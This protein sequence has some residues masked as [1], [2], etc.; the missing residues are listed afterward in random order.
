MSIPTP[1]LL[2][3]A[4]TFA[5]A[6]HG[7][8][9]DK[10]KVPYRHHLAAVA[11]G[12][13]LLGGTTEQIA[14][15]YLHD[16]VEDTKVTLNDLLDHGFPAETVQIVWAVTKQSQELQTVYLDRIIKQGPGAQRVKVADLMHNLRPDRLDQLTSFTRER[17]QEKYRPSLA[18]LMHELGYLVTEVEAEKLAFVPQGTSW[19]VYD[20]TA[21]G[22]TGSY[23]AHS[24]AMLLDNIT[25]L[26]PGDW[27]AGAKAPIAA[28]VGEAPH[29]HYE[30]D[31]GSIWTSDRKT[32]RAWSQTGWVARQEEEEAKGKQWSPFS[33]W[34]TFS[35][36]TDSK[37]KVET[38]KDKLQAALDSVNTSD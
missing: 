23:T 22:T 3:E 28:G 12:V 1:D 15:A 21:S 8:Q 16:V 13:R 34:E 17:L 31:D 18:R 10:L 11:A 38:V 4:R 14:A 19:G 25:M 30:L 24:T 6:K 26:M 27:P 29:T 35:K 7:K 36:V 2:V 33:E 9:V 37:K 5:Y 20:Y 32:I